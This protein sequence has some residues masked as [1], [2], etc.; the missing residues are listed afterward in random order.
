[1]EVTGTRHALILGTENLRS[2][3]FP[4]YAQ[5]GWCIMSANDQDITNRITQDTPAQ[6]FLASLPTGWSNRAASR[7]MPTGLH[8][9][10]NLIRHRLTRQLELAKWQIHFD[11]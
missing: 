1:M 4:H 11:P 5:C 2:S 8:E 10:T 7:P 9:L 3:L 6:H